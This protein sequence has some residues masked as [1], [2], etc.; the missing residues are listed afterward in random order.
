MLFGD[1]SLTL[2]YPDYSHAITS[3]N[4]KPLSSVQDTFKALERM[5]IKGYVKDELGNKLSSF[6]GELSAT[7][8]DKEI[9]LKTKGNDPSSSPFTYNIQK[10]IIF[11]DLVQ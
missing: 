6:N 8:F 1:P 9:T 7:I 10:N 2:A 4:N 11:K 3:I 5:T